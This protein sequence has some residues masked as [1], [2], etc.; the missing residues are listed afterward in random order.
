VPAT[1]RASNSARPDLLAA[2]SALLAEAR[3]LLRAGDV[4][5]ARATLQRLQ[6]RFP[7][8]ELDQEREVLAIEVLSARGQASAAR[9]RARAFVSAH[10]RSPH[11][12]MLTRF[13][14]PP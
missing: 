3:A 5:A 7:R 14:D 9:R 12:A 6:A 4:R 11:S 13:L 10:P 8:G 1:R 2:E